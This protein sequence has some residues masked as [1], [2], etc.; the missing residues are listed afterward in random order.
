[1]ASRNKIYRARRLRGP[2]R[3]YVSVL[4]DREMEDHT[5]WV[6]RFL[7]RLR[8][9]T[10]QQPDL[11]KGVLR[12]GDAD[13]SMILAEYLKG[14][15]AGG[16]T[17]V[18]GVLTE[19]YLYSNT[20]IDGQPSNGELAVDVAARDQDVIIRFFLAPLDPLTWDLRIREVPL[21]D[22]RLTR[23]RDSRFTWPFESRYAGGIVATEIA[24]AVD[25][26][27]DGD[28][29]WLGTE[30]G[31]WRQRSSD[32]RSSGRGV[33]WTWRAVS[34]RLARWM[35]RSGPGAATTATRG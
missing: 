10:A 21:S 33:L 13:P 34:A 30:E 16:I 28:E 29:D 22:P 4:V 24:A 27:V 17:D 23:L 25:R 9:I 11:F 5:E 20:D 2:G 15:P 8:L 19:T 6:N 18:V 14:D 35:A 26:I 3:L 1:M 7:R 31:P 32:S 12:T